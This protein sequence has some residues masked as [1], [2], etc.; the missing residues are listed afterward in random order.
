VKRIESLLSREIGLNPASIGVSA[1]EA[2]VKAR[3]RACELAT[4]ADYVQRL[5]QSPAER[6][7]LV[8]EVVVSET[9]FFRDEEV[10]KALARHALAWLRSERTL[11][12]LSLP[13]ATG[14]ETYSVAIALLEAGLGPT[15]FQVRGVDVS[16]RVLA[17]ARRGVYG[18]S[19]F[20]GVAPQQF[21]GYFEATDAGTALTELPRRPV[22]FSSGNVL[23]ATLFEPRAFD[24]VLCRNLLIYLEPGARTRALENL[25]HWLRDD[26]LLFAGHAEAIELMDS[27]FQRLA[28]AAPF[29]YVK[30][31]PGRGDPARKRAAER[32]TVPGRRRSTGA[33][34]GRSPE[35][36]AA[37]TTTTAAVAAGGGG[38]RASLLQATELANAGKLRDARL[39]CERLIAESG[40]SPQAYCLLGIINKALG[41]SAAAIDA[42]N[43]SLYLEPAH[44]ESLVHLALLYEQLGERAA[45]A[46]FRRR[47][48]RARGGEGS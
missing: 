47:A 44:Y 11:R 40:A 24:V 3:L 27:R 45:A 15:R 34:R 5:E 28:E 20:R 42:F 13:C 38:P 32:T 9:W 21:R 18:K 36:K 35:A 46:N 6:R 39:S 19:S 4:L 10:F 29:A 7:A 16:E 26:G 17:H 14:E 31:P 8:E 12:V 2:A 23:D 33:T 43:K 48:E 25:A 41:E 22:T 37:A 30:P 1:I